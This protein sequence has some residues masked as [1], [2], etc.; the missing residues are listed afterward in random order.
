MSLLYCCIYLCGERF[1][2][3]N[4]KFNT[5]TN[6]T[7]NKRLSTFWIMYQ[8]DDSPVAQKEVKNKTVNRFWF[9]DQPN[10]ASRWQTVKLSQNDRMSTA[11]SGNTQDINANTMYLINVARE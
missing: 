10:G 1:N 4:N 6:L 7:L 9:T 2:N 8:H 11:Q 5:N 3:K